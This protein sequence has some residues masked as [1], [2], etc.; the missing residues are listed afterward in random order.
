[1]V[2]LNLFGRKLSLQATTPRPATAIE[3]VWKQ[4]LP[5]IVSPS[6]IVNYTQLSY[7]V[8]CSLNF[9]NNF[10]KFLLRYYVGLEPWTHASLLLAQ[11][12]RFSASLHNNHGVENR[13]E[14]FTSEYIGE[15]KSVCSNYRAFIHMAE[16][17]VR[18]EITHSSM[19]KP[20]IGY[21]LAIQ[22][23]SFIF[24]AFC[25]CALTIEINV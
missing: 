12:V 16:A 2:T 5:A 1:M 17:R 21:A 10:M 9:S 8:S 22:N 15:P 6:Y 25:I 14:T 3:A 4:T 23:T 7:L 20:T 18:W 24:V 11:Y 13:I 19:H